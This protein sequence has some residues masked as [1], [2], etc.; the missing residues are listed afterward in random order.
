[1][2]AIV[3]PETAGAAQ[4]TT[5]QQDELINGNA[6]EFEVFKAVNDTVVDLP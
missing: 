5:T 3:E 4:Q 2:V 6:T 1:M